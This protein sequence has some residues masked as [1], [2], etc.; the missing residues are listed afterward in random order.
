MLK[1]KNHIIDFFFFHS[2]ENWLLKAMPIWLGD[3]CRLQVVLLILVK[4]AWSLRL[5]MVQQPL[6]DD[7]SFSPGK[8]KECRTN[9][10][11]D[12]DIGTGLVWVFSPNLWPLLG[13]GQS[14][15]RAMGFVSLQNL[16]IQAR[17]C[18]LAPLS[19]PGTIRA[20]SL[21]KGY[22]VPYLYFTG[23][24]TETHG[25]ICKKIIKANV[26]LSDFFLY[27]KSNM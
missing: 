13:R 8:S 14:L 12:F 9:L 16:S 3:L 1:N 2:T 25:H 24:E 18:H 5:L 15:L 20:G 7:T 21:L 11:S 19:I 27:F 6:R 26:I 22:L 23:R 17:R 4:M 10:S